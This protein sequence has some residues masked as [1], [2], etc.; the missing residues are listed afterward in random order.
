P[1]SEKHG[2]DQNGSG[3]FIALASTPTVTNTASRGARDRPVSPAADAEAMYAPA[4]LAAVT[5]KVPA[6]RSSATPWND[7]WK[8]ANSAPVR[9]RP[10]SPYTRDSPP[11][12]SIRRH[13]WCPPNQG[14]RS[15]EH[16]SELQ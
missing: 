8:T 3:P 16:T 2:S 12:S 10:S 9:N 13:R 6:T 4:A 7:F 1:T 15:E 5:Q 11:T 14:R